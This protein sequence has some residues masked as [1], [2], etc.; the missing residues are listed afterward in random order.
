MKDLIFKRDHYHAQADDQGDM[1]QQTPKT[2]K[3]YWLILVGVLIFSG[4]LLVRLTQSSGQATGNTAEGCG[5]EALEEIS[6]GVEKGGWV[7]AS[8]L[9]SQ[10]PQDRTCV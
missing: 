2:Q 4:P 9:D 3:V 6:L 1:M 10:T 5:G 7:E 8:T